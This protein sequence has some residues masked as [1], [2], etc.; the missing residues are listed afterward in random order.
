MLDTVSGAWN[1]FSLVQKNFFGF[2]RAWSDIKKRIP[3][4]WR[5][6][7]RFA[8]LL[9]RTNFMYVP[10]HLPS[11]R[12][13]SLEFGQQMFGRCLQPIYSSKVLELSWSQFTVCLFLLEAMCGSSRVPIGRTKLNLLI[14]WIGNL[15]PYS[16]H[17][18]HLKTKNC[19]NKWEH[20]YIKLV[21]GIFIFCLFII[22]VQPFSWVGLTVSI[23]LFP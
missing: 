18:S 16:T 19:I 17:I 10:I 1:C 22:Y 15:R 6:A 8:W 4:T 14:D 7:F 23:R 3:P 21:K 2:I 12:S 9:F 20:L 5:V 13:Q 11:L